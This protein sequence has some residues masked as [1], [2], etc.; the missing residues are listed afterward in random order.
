MVDLKGANRWIPLESNPETLTAQAHKLGMSKD[1]AFADVFGLEPDLLSMLPGPCLALLLLFPITDNTRKSDEAEKARIE[2]EGQVVSPNVYFMKQTIS[3]ACGTIAL[4]HALGNAAGISIGGDF[5]IFYDATRNMKPD[6]IA[7]Y[8]ENDQSLASAHSDCAQ[9]GQTE[10]PPLETSV[11]E[12]FVCLAPIDGH[13]YELD[14]RKE[15]PVNHGACTSDSFLT[16]GARVA[17]SFMAR[18]PDNI[19]FTVMALCR[20][21]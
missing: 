20:V 14:G 13:L 21:D 12:H 11:T 17:K 6:E 16:E 19:N 7:K 1:A 9:E 15:Y 5:K 4:L 10:A 8:V 2:K 3:N 18:D